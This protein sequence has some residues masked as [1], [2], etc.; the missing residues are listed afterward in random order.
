MLEHAQ[1]NPPGVVADP[2]RR[3]PLNG[4]TVEGLDSLLRPKLLLEERQQ[5]QPAR[6]EAG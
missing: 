1:D 2:L 5:R 4:Q 3:S 6:T